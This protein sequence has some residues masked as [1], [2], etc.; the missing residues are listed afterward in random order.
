MNRMQCFFFIFFPSVII[1]NF[2]VYCVAFFPFKANA[3]L[4]VY[5]NA[6][7]PCPIAGQFFQPVG[8]RYGKI[9]DI[10]RNVYHT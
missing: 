5:A 2:Y 7:L 6:V 10:L 3:P 1:G 9:G 8:W 4:V